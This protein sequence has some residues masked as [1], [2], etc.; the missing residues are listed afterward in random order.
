MQ[1]ICC[2][3]H[4]IFQNPYNL[5]GFSRCRTCGFT[6]RTADEPPDQLDNLVEHYENVDPHQAV[7]NSKQKFFYEALDHLINPQNMEKSLLDVGCGYGYFLA[8]AQKRGWQTAGVEISGKA[9]ERA[10]MLPA[11][12]N[13]ILGTLK[14]ASFSNSSFD[15]ITLW[16][17]LAYFQDPYQNLVECFRILK[18]GGEI[19]IRVRN[20]EFQ[21]TIYRII[22]PFKKIAMRFG[23]KN[24]YVF[25]RY[26]F[27]PRSILYLLRRSGFERIQI[28]NSTLTQGD[29]YEHT[30][31][32]GFLNILKSWVHL[33]SNVACWLTN[34]RLI[35]GP[36]LL[37]WAEKPTNRE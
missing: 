5:C 35:I 19:G 4:D 24:P 29:P 21:T 3:S 33:I 14:R 36:S 17:V 30:K 27:S 9:V 20:V 16:D 11:N 37:I 10:R 23:F 6:F 28:T 18:N 31:F 15:A 8:M 7:A 13:I 26:C 25:N 12:S 1:C 32:D 34:G 22:K 2:L